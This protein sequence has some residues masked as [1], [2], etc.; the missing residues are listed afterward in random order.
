MSQDE[1]KAAAVYDS[2]KVETLHEATSQLLECIDQCLFAIEF[3]YLESLDNVPEIPA[4]IL[5][6]AVS[7]EEIGDTEQRA[8]TEA[9][10]LSIEGVLQICHAAERMRLPTRDFPYLLMNE[11]GAPLSSR[12]NYRL[13]V[14]VQDLLRDLPHLRGKRHVVDTLAADML[15]EKPE[16]GEMLD[17]HA[18][19]LE[20]YYVA[21]SDLISFHGEAEPK[22]VR[23]RAY[24]K[25]V[26]LDKSGNPWQ[27]AKVAAHT[28]QSTGDAA[29]KS[30]ERYADEHNLP[31]V[32]PP[33]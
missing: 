7:N 22:S 27:W 2:N 16:I 9:L 5:A 29:R 17:R 12:W 8:V 19:T 21:L 24:E 3:L 6:L 11:E 4:S 30:T 14:A 20:P 13:Y 28:G 25:A 33:K 1:D 26:E 23:Q 10:R 15:S 32:S 31:R 18:C